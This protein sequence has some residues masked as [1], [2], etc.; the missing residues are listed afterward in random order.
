MHFPS[1][2]LLGKYHIVSDTGSTSI[3]RRKICDVYAQLCLIE[4]HVI[5]SEVHPL[6]GCS[7]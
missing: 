1:N 3:L 2:L 5:K 7:F 4:T 6:S